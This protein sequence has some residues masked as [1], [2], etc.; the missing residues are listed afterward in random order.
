MVLFVF[1]TGRGRKIMDVCFCWTGRGRKIMFVCVL[2][3]VGG[4]KSKIY[5]FGT[6]RGAENY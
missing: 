5:V 4:G 1:R 3:L 2:G 6:G